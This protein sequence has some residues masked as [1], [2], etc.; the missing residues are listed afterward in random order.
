MRMI[1]E[2]PLTREEWTRLAKLIKEMD[3]GRT[4]RVI[5]MFFD[6]AE[7]DIFPTPA[8]FR[9]WADEVE[10]PHTAVVP[11]G[12]EVSFESGGGVRVVPVQPG[13]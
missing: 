12:D 8:D 11:V 10:L 5:T 9:A 6:E 1:I 4:D 13:G 7:N 3:E 2:G